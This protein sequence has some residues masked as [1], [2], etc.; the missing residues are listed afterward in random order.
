M[1]LRGVVLALTVLA[2]QFVI[3]C[4]AHV[5]PGLLE[6]A[7]AKRL[8]QDVWTIPW[9]N[10]S[11]S[12][13]DAPQSVAYEFGFH[14]SFRDA[15]LERRRADDENYKLS[16]IYFVS[17]ERTRG[18]TVAN[19]KRYLV[20]SL[21]RADAVSL[22]CRRRLQRI[23]DGTNYSDIPP[24]ACSGLSYD[25]GAACSIAS[26]RKQ[27]LRQASYLAAKIY[28]EPLLRVATREIGRWK[29]K[30]GCSEVKRQRG[31]LDHYSSVMSY[32]TD[33]ILN[34]QILSEKSADILKLKDVDDWVG[35]VEHPDWQSFRSALQ[36]SCIRSR[37]AETEIFLAL[38]CKAAGIRKG[39]N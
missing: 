5:M 16:L 25:V 21:I 9:D 23:L 33:I 8:S 35:T 15:N 29:V 13:P 19:A 10:G 14:S 12:I 1:G 20:D 38:Q 28:Q 36:Y 32:P 39:H 27:A 11:V 37:E 31:A 34:L 30:N 22:S 18:Q 7:E 26:D 2:T 17:A 24:N 3:S 6:N 4:P